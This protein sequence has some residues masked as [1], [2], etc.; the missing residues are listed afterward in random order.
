MQSKSHKYVQGNHSVS[1]MILGLWIFRPFLKIEIPT[2][3]EL[4]YFPLVLQIS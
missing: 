4:P 2:M 1:S 3:A